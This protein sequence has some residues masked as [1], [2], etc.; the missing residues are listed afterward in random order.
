MEKPLGYIKDIP[1]KCIKIDR[2]KQC[3]KIEGRM[4]AKPGGDEGDYGLSCMGEASEIKSDVKA[5]MTVRLAKLD[6]SE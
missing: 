2:K 4:V 1:L 3:V 6:G 5:S